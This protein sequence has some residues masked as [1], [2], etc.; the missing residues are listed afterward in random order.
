[1]LP[2]LKK[3]AVLSKILTSKL[4]AKRPLGRPR[5]RWKGIIRKKIKEKSCQSEELG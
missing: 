5:R 1:M 3:V 4:T 2:E